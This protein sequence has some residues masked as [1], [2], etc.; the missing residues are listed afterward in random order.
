LPY[1]KEEEEPQMIILLKKRNKNA[2][3]HARLNNRWAQR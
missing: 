2:E 1:F 3:T